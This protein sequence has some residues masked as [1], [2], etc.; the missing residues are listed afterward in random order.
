MK[1][2]SSLNPRTLKRNQAKPHIK[3]KQLGTE[4]QL[5]SRVEV[6]AQMEGKQSQGK[7]KT[8]TS[9]TQQKRE[10]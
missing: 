7:E 9:Q 8:F 3:K 10:L 6:Q 2:W 1:K 4:S 5:S